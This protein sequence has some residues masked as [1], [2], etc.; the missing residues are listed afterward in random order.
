MA[1][2]QQLWDGGLALAALDEDPTDNGHRCDGENA[3]TGERQ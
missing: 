2:A 3:A 1:A